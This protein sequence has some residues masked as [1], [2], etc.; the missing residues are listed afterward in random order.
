MNKIIIFL[1]TFSSIVVTA[2]TEIIGSVLE[3]ESQKTLEFAEVVLLN[4]ESSI[5]AGAVT[6]A[7]GVFKLNTKQGNYTIQV[8]YVGQILYTKNITVA[9]KPINLGV[10]EIV[11]AQELDEVFIA[12]KK[13][14]IERKIDRLV[15]NVENSSKAS[16]GDALEV[17]RV[18][19]GVRVQNDQITMIGKSNLQVMINDKIVQL[20]NEDLINF[21]RSI[22]SEDIKNIEV[23]TTPPAKYEASGNSG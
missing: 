16:Q 4:N 10:I 13:K 17:L 11:N 6:D 21:L 12:A 15:F 1:I 19:P 14:L 20:S 18:A 22:A 7:N 9:E 3:K 2:Q 5:I 23:I 8:T